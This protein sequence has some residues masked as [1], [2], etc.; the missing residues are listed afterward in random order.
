MYALNSEEMKLMDNSAINEYGIPSLILMESASGHVHKYI[1]DNFEKDKKILIISGSGNNGGDGLCL[2]R[3]LKISGYSLIVFS[4]GKENLI[5]KESNIQL[6][7]ILK[8]GVEHYRIENEEDEKNFKKFK[9]YLISAD[10]IIDAI[11]G[12]SLNRKVGGIYFDII[13]LIN[14]SKK[15]VLALDIPSGVSADTG[16]IM[17]I[18]VKADITFTF[19]YPKIGLYLYPSPYYVGKLKICDIGIPKLSEKKLVNP[20]EIIDETVFFDLPPRKPDTHKGSFGKV[21]VIAGSNDMA[22]AAA[23]ASKSAYRSG[24]GLVYVFTEEERKGIILSYVPEAIV[25]GYSSKSE[26]KI[27]NEKL[28][29]LIKKTDTILIGSGLE[30][31]RLSLDILKECINSEKPLVIDAGALNLISKNKKLIKD[32]KN[33]NKPSVL[34]PH[35][36]E[37]A[38]LTG[39]SVEE[40]SDDLIRTA[41]KFASSNKIILCLKSARTVIAFPN[42]KIYLNIIGNNGMATAGSGDVLAGTI[43]S[44]LAEYGENYTEQAVCKA[45]YIHSRAGDRALE[46]R[47]AYSLIASDLIDN[48]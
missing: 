36:G 20:V 27:I 13:K 21:L 5:S 31:S 16:K 38:R 40:I 22:G 34:T 37:M 43:A 39:K 33:R 26:I 28:T 3:Q 1:L 9:K 2:A 4:I 42:E 8:L 6:N 41:K 10:I 29:D 46:K 44:Q 30:E 48:L 19:G 7:S 47:E 15:T 25:Y 12:I 17:G 24:C 32:L 11:F 18:S 14:H 35:L 23:L 45:V